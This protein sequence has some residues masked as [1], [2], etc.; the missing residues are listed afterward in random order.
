MKARHFFYPLLFLFLVAMFASCSS[1]VPKSPEQ[2]VEYNEDFFSIAVSDV[3]DTIKVYIEDLV[4]SLVILP[5]DNDKKALCAPLTVYI[6]EQHIGLTPSERGG[7]YK[8]FSRPCLLPIANIPNNST[9]CFRSLRW[10]NWNL[11]RRPICS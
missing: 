11:Y 3:K 6:T 2:R 9:L 8:L 1:S 5:L 7:T 4:D 10:Q